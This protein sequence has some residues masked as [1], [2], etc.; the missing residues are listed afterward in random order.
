MG[1]VYRAR[2][3]KLGRDVAIKF[4]QERLSGSREYL[5]RFEREARAA[6]ALNHPN[7]VT[8]FEIDQFRGSPFIAMELVEG[9]SLRD[10]AA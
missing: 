2:D 10:V 5:A 3:P 9:S 7:I 4:L 6:S 8:I 1:D